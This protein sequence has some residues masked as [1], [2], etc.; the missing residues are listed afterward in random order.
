MTTMRTY[1]QF[2]SCQRGVALVVSMIMLVL[3]SLMAAGGFFL[4]TEE[5]RGASSWSDRQRALFAA[6]GAL[7]EAEAAV[8]QKIAGSANVRQTVLNGGSG[9]YV[10]HVSAIPEVSAD[11]TW[12]AGPALPAALTMQADKRLEDEVYYFVVFEG[13]GQ[14]TGNALLTG[15]GNVNDTAKNPRFT[16]YAKA[17]G[18][19]KGTLV[20]LTTSTEL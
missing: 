18:I 4:S 15:S 12:K 11:S 5:A 20:V 3:A 9:Y 7:K 19:K 10:R 8:R 1:P 2:P 17:G 13:Y 16:L 14:A 6:E